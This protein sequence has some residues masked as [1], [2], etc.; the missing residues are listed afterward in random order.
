[1]VGRAGERAAAR[2]TDLLTELSSVP[3]VTAVCGPD[4]LR[5]LL[6]PAAAVGTAGAL[7]DRALAHHVDRQV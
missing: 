6:D 3:E 4:E 1:V 5:R 2:S 7:V